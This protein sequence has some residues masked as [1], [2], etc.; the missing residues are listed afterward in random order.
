VRNFG[1][2]ASQA[3]GA[4]ISAQLRHS[5]LEVSEADEADYVVLNTCTVTSTADAD[6]RQTVRRIHQENPAAK[7]VVTGCY[8]QRAPDEIAALPGV[9]LVIGNSHKTQMASLLT[10]AQ[11]FHGEV[12]VSDIFQQHDFLA[13]AV[14][15]PVDGRA[16]P[17][18]KIQDGCSNRCS[19]CVI[20]YV[21]GNSRS[22]SRHD[23][24]HQIKDLAHNF[25]EVVLTG[26]NL[27]RWG[28]E[29]GFADR[30][31]LSDLVKAILAETEVQRLRL[32]SVEPMDWTDELIELVA[33]EPRIA[34]HV[35]APLQSGSDSVLRRMFRKY[36][37]RH[38]EN[39]LQM[40]KSRVPEAAIGADVMTGFPGETE[41]EFRQ[42]VDFIESQPFTYLHVFT[43]SERTG[44]PAAS[45]ET[46]VPMSVRK[47]RT[48]IL[49]ALGD[50]KKHAFAAKVAGAGRK[51]S[52]VVLQSQ[53]MALTSNFLEVELAQARIPGTLVAVEVTA[54]GGGLRERH[55]FPILS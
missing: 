37:T 44:T 15:S 22:A 1:C 5:G 13:S 39:R 47:E 43:Y 9:R 55:A 24:I 30:G 52:A 8:A 42:T 45:Y 51:V 11:P 26:I 16:R 34:K 49:R 40:V 23:I 21:R 17:N 29:H 3:D 33:D 48:A 53:K 10:Q 7:I 41:E 35:H 32:S 46:S 54:E 38:Y 25:A 6:L 4:A 36:R 19:F 27:G 2:R 50:K 31:R 20:P 28:R 18:L 14:E 12:F